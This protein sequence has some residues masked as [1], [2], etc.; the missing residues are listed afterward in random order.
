MKRSYV[1]LAVLLLGSGVIAAPAPKPFVS[2]W[3]NPVNPDRD[4][5]IRRD[6][7]TLI[8]EMPGTDHDYDPIRKHFNAPRI[9]RDM[10]GDFEINVRVQI[11]RR[12]SAKSTAKGQ[13][14]CV[15]AGFLLIYPDT[16]RTTCIRSEYGFPQ[17]GIGLD[18]YAAASDLP[19]PRR[20]RASGTGIGEDGYAAMKDFYCQVRP[21]D[22]TWNHGDQKQIRSICD[23]GWKDWPFAKKSDY[24]YLRLEQRGNWITFFISPDG[25]KWTQLSS[26]SGQPTKFKLGLAAYSTSTDPSKFRFD[27]LKLTRGKR[28]SK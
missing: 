20:E 8:I 3:S 2:G 11:E 28:N 18:G 12:P 27:Q 5:K 9:L 4:C 15:S 10:E 25:K 17:P 14:S 19:Y 23:R 7:A 21:P 26:H 24:A 16:S 6:E 1:T 13:P 22:M